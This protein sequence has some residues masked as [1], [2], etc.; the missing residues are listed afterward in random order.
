ML[1]GGLREYIRRGATCTGVPPGLAG[2]QLKNSGEGRTVHLVQ[3]WVNTS[4]R[5][6]RL[7][8]RKTDWTSVFPERRGICRFCK[9]ALSN[10]EK[11]NGNCDECYR[12]SV[13]QLVH[14][15]APRWWYPTE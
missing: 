11:D 10:D 8:T 6:P 5:W 14:K 2:T 7:N 15:C 3:T 13:F 4:L 1:V 12:V 9:K